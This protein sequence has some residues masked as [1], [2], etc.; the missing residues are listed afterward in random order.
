MQSSILIYSTFESERLQYVLQFVFQEFFHISY[1]LTTDESQFNLYS[2]C[3]I[4]YSYQ[5]L[6]GVFAITSNKMLNEN[7]VVEKEIRM[8][9]WNGMPIFF[10]VENDKI[11]FDIFAAIFYLISRYEEYLPYEPDRFS[12]FPHTQSLAFKEGFLNLPLVDMWLIEFAKLLSQHFPNLKINLSKFEFLPTYDIDIAYS[13][14]GKGIRRTIGGFVRDI[15]S[16][17]LKFVKNRLQVLIGKI[18]DPYDSYAW[19]DTLH[20][21]YNLNP[22]YFILLSDGG[23]L[24]KNL[25]FDSKSMK[26]LL[27]HLESN[28]NV[29]I[30]PSWKSHQD[31]NILKRELNRLYKVTRSRQ[32]YIRFSLSETF[33]KLINLGILEEYSMGYGSING[34]RASTSRDFYWFDLDRNCATTLK[35]IPFCYMECNSRF[36]QGYSLE[37]AGKEL[38][39][40]FQITQKVSG[41][42]VTV[43]HNFSLGTDPFWDGWS[44]MYLAC[45]ENAFRSNLDSSID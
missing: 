11:P 24:D 45:V 43:F 33:F 39:S 36:E 22:V 28:Y 12:R 34:F 31:I 3:K 32:H 29:G 20:T 26:D 16:G 14:L 19:L 9:G 17:N 41:R 6:E 4:N 42:M 1:E 2:G 10:L 40:Y 35:C 38:N 13:Y 15:L 37:E 27:Y 23:K 8:G 30:H 21:R 25:D 5:A 44:S 7:N 18:K